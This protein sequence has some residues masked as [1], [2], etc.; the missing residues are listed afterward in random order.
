MWQHISKSHVFTTKVVAA[1]KCLLAAFNAALVF[2]ISIIVMPI[3]ASLNLISV[4]VVA[5]YAADAD[6]RWCLRWCKSYRLWKD[7]NLS[8]LLVMA[9][10]INLS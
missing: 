5:A 3:I 2:F 6:F 7:V 8:Q 4:V 9:I 1:D 10:Q